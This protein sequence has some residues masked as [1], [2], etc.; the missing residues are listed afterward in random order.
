M[1]ESKG[2]IEK[3]VW[4]QAS[5]EIVFQALTRAS[6]LEEWFCDK[7]DS[8]ARAGGE[9]T[10]Q[11]NVG[12]VGSG[13]NGVKERRKGRAV[14]TR[15]EPG[16]ALELHWMDDGRGEDSDIAASAHTSNYE[17]H[18]KAGMT[19]LALTD[20]DDAEMDADVLTYLDEGWNAVLMELKDY[21]E[22]MA[23]AAKKRFKV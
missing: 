8:D 23:R 13:W 18:P 10:A 3:K 17:I 2:R 15:F 20:S 9:I 11:W 7:A 14:I 6:A 12:N 4:I 5:A 19:E 21:C 22:H 16:R 1:P